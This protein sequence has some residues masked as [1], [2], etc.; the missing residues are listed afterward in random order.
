LERSF[1]RESLLEDA[2][3]LAFGSRIA[4]L[5]LLFG[6]VM[7][8]AAFVE[9]YHSKPHSISP[10][11]E[12]FDP[13]VLRE[14]VAAARSVLDWAEQSA[15]PAPND[16]GNRSG[17]GERAAAGFWGWLEKHPDGGGDQQM[18]RIAERLAPLIE[19]SKTR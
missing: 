4:G 5:V 11:D 2:L 18:T 19:R 9:A 1:D 6:G 17:P 15:A 3:D 8:R 10:D 14:V 12:L 7:M 13:N 16:R